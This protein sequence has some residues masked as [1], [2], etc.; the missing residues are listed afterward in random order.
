MRTNIDIDDDLMRVA[1]QAS[2]E[3]TKPRRRIGNRIP[4]GRS[5]RRRMEPKRSS[6]SWRTR[7][8]PAPTAGPLSAPSSVS[9]FH[10]TDAPAF[11]PAG[12]RLNDDLYVLAE[13]GQE[14][15]QPIA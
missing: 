10:D 12:L 14:A 4:V 9:L 1:L 6:G 2:G 5:G 13:G 11:A 7:I 8:L 3:R 15:H